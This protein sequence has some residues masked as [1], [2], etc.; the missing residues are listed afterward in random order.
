MTYT[1]QFTDEEIKALG[2]ILGD[3]VLCA[4]NKGWQKET[5]ET[6]RN[7][8]K[9]VIHAEE[10]CPDVLCEDCTKKCNLK[11][12][13]NKAEKL[14]I[15]GIDLHEGSGMETVKD[16]IKAVEELKPYVDKAIKEMKE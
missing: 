3:F 10:T 4:E 9:K 7:I 2:G 16:A 8:F 13:L 5:I 1:L 6:A 12:L 11:R 15:F 14:G